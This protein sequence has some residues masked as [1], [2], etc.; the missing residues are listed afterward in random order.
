MIPFKT[1][2]IEDRPWIADL[3]KN[4]RERGCEYNFVNLY[5]WSEPFHL[6]V[7]EVAGCLTARMHGAI[8]PCYL[9][10]VGGDVRAAILALREDAR[11]RGLPFNMGCLTPE[12]IQQV[13]VWFP[14]CFAFEADRDGYDYLY[15]IERLATLRGKKLHGKRNHINRFLEENPDWAFEEITSDNLADCLSMDELWFRE[16]KG[17]AGDDTFEE[18]SLALHKVIT[19]YDKMGLDGGLIRVDGKV[20]AFTMVEKMGAGDTYDVHFEK[21]F[22]EIQGA[23]PMI[24]REFARWVQAHYPE[25]RYLNRED[26]MGVEGLRQA[27]NSYYPDLMVEKSA[28]Y[29]RKELS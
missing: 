23:Y 15:D 5:A 19:D 12:H 27:K 3:L 8:G 4:T 6:E 22:S 10:P 18:D 28:A 13:E 9:Y 26:D 29:L 11:E 1:P 2:Q 24:N 20:V 14:G 17:Y 16:N 21:A 25:V 7:A